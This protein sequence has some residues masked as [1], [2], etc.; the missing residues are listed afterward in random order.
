M[1]SVGGDPYILVSDLSND[2][3][4]YTKFYFKAFIPDI[5]SFEGY[6]KH[7]DSF[8]CMKILRLSHGLFGLLFENCSIIPIVR[9]DFMAK[10][11]VLVRQ[12][13]F[14]AWVVDMASFQDPSGSSGC[15]A[16]LVAGKQ[17][18]YIAKIHDDGADIAKHRSDNVEIP[19]PEP[20]AI[21]DEMLNPKSILDCSL[22]LRQQL[23]SWHTLRRGYNWSE[24]LERQASSTK[25]SKPTPLPT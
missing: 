25:Y 6:Q 10:S 20:L 22:Q 9:I 16:I 15:I 13:S 7:A 23:F 4:Q 24:K 12:L 2:N 8:N 19:E 14:D 21:H 17:S 5:S 1:L 18:V 3:I 11:I